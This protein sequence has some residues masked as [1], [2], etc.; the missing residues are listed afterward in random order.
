MGSEKHEHENVE[1]ETE[2]EEVKER[3]KKPYT[4]PHLTKFGRVEE[5]TGPLALS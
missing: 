4:T 5:H 1:K 3:A 2:R